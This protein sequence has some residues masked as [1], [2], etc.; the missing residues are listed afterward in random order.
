MNFN[1]IS[2]SGYHM[3]EAGA[4]AAQEVAFTLANAL[5]YVGRAL[6]P[7]FRSRRSAPD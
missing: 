7:E 1:P 3:R 6:A 5:E 4:T 2:I